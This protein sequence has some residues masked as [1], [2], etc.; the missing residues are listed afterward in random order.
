MSGP[1]TDQ[2]H[3][4]SRSTRQDINRDGRATSTT[5]PY[6]PDPFAGNAESEAHRGGRTQSRLRVPGRAEFIAFPMR[7]S[8]FQSTIR[9][10][11]SRRA[12]V[13]ETHDPATLP[14]GYGLSGAAPPVP[15]RR[16]SGP[17]HQYV[18]EVSEPELNT[19]SWCKFHAGDVIGKEALSASA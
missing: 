10:T 1:S 4:S 7:P 8:M 17:R 3:S 5:M 16:N 18:G 14:D 13:R 11:H 15:Q 6:S 2:V 19:R 9:G 12:V